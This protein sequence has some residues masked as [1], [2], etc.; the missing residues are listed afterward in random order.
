[1]A[2][3]EKKVMCRNVQEHNEVA[4]TKVNMVNYVPEEEKKKNKR[5]VPASII[6]DE[7]SENTV[8]VEES[9]PA[10]TPQPSVMPKPP[11]TQMPTMY[12]DSN[13]SEIESNFVFDNA[14]KVL[15][16][17]NKPIANFHIA[18]TQLSSV[19]DNKTGRCIG[20]MI[21]GICYV[22]H[23]GKCEEHHFYKLNV[24]EVAN[25]DFI[26]MMPYAVTFVSKSEF[27]NNLYAYINSLIFTYSGG[28]VPTFETSGW[29]KISN[30]EN[31]YVTSEGAIGYPNLKIF[32]CDGFR[33][34]DS[35]S[36]SLYEQFQNMRQTLNRPEQMDA[37]LIYTLGQM[38]HALFDEANVSLKHILFI[39][40]PRGSGKTAVALCFTQLDNKISP[41]FN[42]QATESGLQVHLMYYRDRVMLIDDLAPSA[43]MVDRKQKEHKLESIIRLFGDNTERVINTDFMKAN[44]NKIDYSVYGGAVITGEY[45]YSTGSESSIAR[46]VVVELGRESVNW[47][48]LTYFQQNPQILESLA[49]RFISFVSVNYKWTLNTIRET[50]EYY[51]REMPQR[52]FS[53]KRYYDY[54]GQ[55]VAVGKILMA[56]FHS[57][58]G[59]D[60]LEQ[61]SYLNVLERGL[62][63]LLNENDQSMKQKAPINEVV[64]SLIYFI[65]SGN[66]GNWGDPITEE[67]PLII[68]DGMIYLR[69][70]DLPGIKQKYANKINI[71]Q[72]SMSSTDM[73][74]LLE[75]HGYCESYME[76]NKKRLG[77][78]YNDYGNE[79]LMSIPLCK[80]KEFQDTMQIDY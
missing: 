24:D 59:I 32:A 43:D 42:F 41:K 11:Q 3:N 18:I 25:C 75:M 71:P 52:R 55:Y 67:T 29:R 26:N 44:R 6:N 1:M 79:R 22:W 5:I 39:V 58:S 17:G 45:F 13:A 16:K 23:G 61:Q 7:H 46:A 64:M 35:Y 15:Y 77:K 63:S 4:K 31:V 20:K 28:V 21:D 56:F 68:S 14:N 69:Q 36:G 80:I 51:R 34:R 50:V 38:M 54:L 74:K 33:I 73:G 78:K 8:K 70:K 49:Y 10:T 27:S 37:I 2:E 19:C 72:I 48:L 66:Y 30:T 76:G 12:G 53:N 40:G 57:D 47:G 9:V 62:S 60:E 65:E